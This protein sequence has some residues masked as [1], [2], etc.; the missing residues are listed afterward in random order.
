MLLGL[1]GIRTH[2][3]YGQ[4][5]ADQVETISA[6]AEKHGFVLGRPRLERSY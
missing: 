5:S 2:Y 4:I 3:S 6:V 1:E